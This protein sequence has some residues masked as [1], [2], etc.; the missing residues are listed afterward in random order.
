MSKEPDQ[1]II[2]VLEMTC[3]EDDVQP[4]EKTVEK[5]VMKKTSRI[6]FQKD[7]RAHLFLTRHGRR[8]RTGILT[9]EWDRN[10]SDFAK[11]TYFSRISFIG[12]DEIKQ[13]ARRTKHAKGVPNINVHQI[14][15]GRMMEVN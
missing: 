14:V 7:E 4:D 1:Q 8:W 11:I 12:A 13:T 5:K 9:R 2:D 10:E 6:Q 3:A 15:N